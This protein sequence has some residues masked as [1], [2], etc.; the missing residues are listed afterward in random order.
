TSAS[1]P[2]NSVTV[3]S[4]ITEEDCLLV[5]I[6]DCG[7]GLPPGELHAINERLAAP[8]APDASVS[9]Q[10]GLFVVSKLAGRHSIRVRLRQQRGD[11]GITA[12][13]LLP[14][15]LVSVDSSAESL[16]PTPSAVDGA[17]GAGWSGTNPDMPLRVRVVE[18]A[19]DSDQLTPSSICGLMTVRRRRPRTA[20]EEWFELFG[21][22]EPAHG[23][24]QT[25]PSGSGPVADV[26]E[27]RSVADVPEQAREEIFESVSAWFRADRS[28]APPMPTAV[29]WRS[30]GDDG[31][32]A[33]K[34]LRTQVDEVT[35]VGLPRRQPGAQ[36]MP[37]SAG[38]SSSDLAPRANISARTAEEVRGRLSS[39]Q[40][41]LRY[42]RH[43]RFGLGDRLARTP[44]RQGYSDEGSCHSEEGSQ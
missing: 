10:M 26:P 5:E 25:P 8:P 2:E 32:S 44:A 4:G 35:A 15:A 12:S 43:S 33:A 20:E 19:A 16:V 36:L 13:V 1:P 37:G 34:V 29:E 24:D 17:F 27:A 30:A 22:E 11:F 9:R 6:V 21:H 41:G 40:R 18:G 31:W 28:A 3:R 23:L 7:T 14:P 39:Y 38:P 42:G